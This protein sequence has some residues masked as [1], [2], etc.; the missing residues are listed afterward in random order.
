MSAVGSRLE[1][2][3][4]GPQELCTQAAGSVWA[5]AYREA[6][7]HVCGGLEVSLA[8][9]D[10]PASKAVD[11][12]VTTGKSVRFQDREVAGR[13]DG[14]SKVGVDPSRLERQFFASET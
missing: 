11:T 6:V 2:R 13:I 10:N 7:A 5:A 14:R 1:S 12:P 3:D 8:Q 9:S 4:A